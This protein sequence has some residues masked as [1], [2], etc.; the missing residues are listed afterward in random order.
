M[1]E[2]PRPVTFGRTAPSLGVRDIDSAIGFYCGVLGMTV[3]FE[4]GSPTGFVIVER[5]VAEIH[6]TR[7]AS[8]RPGTTNVAHLIVDDAEALYDHVVQAGVR[9]IKGLRREDYGMV[10]F[11][12][13]DPD[14]NRIDVGQQL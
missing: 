6:L 5:D 10:A 13:A 8:H 12:M 9:I 7:D 1:S 11:V 4:N 2:Q 14:G 3:T